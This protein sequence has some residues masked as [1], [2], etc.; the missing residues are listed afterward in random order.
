[1][2]WR[3]GDRI[4][5]SVIDVFMEGHLVNVDLGIMVGSSLTW[6]ALSSVAL[7]SASLVGLQGG[8]SEKR[9]H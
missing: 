7:L 2:R 9:K 3:L 4:Q 5:N 6:L 8:V 1:M